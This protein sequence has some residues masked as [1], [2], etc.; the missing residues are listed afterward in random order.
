MTLYYGEVEQKLSLKEYE[1]N[2]MRDKIDYLKEQL[3]LK[4]E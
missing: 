1:I 2:G 4:N 3:Q